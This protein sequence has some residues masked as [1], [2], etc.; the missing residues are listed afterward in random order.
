M[1][2]P[3]LS[4]FSPL[5]SLALFAR[6][7]CCGWHKSETL[8]G[9]SLQ[10]P[11]GNAKSLKSSALSRG[12]WERLEEHREGGRGLVATSTLQSP[13]VAALVTWHHA[14][15][16]ARQPFSWPLLDANQKERDSQHQW[17]E[18][19]RLRGTENSLHNLAATGE[20]R[21][22]AYLHNDPVRQSNLKK[23][24]CSKATQQFSG[25]HKDLNPALPIT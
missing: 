19:R 4:A 3:C 23:G 5:P 8:K 1:A 13:I 16:G 2:H 6:S 25:R 7:S 9:K 18:T 11:S 10:L 20:A 17:Q 15:R 22:P 24:D 14:A 21:P 12:S